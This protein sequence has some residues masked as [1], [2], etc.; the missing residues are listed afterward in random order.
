MTPMHAFLTEMIDRAGRSFATGELAYLALTSKIERPF[1]DRLAFA[2][3]VELAPSGVHVAREFF[4]AGAGRADVAIL[5]G[6]QTLCLVEGKAMA[7]ADCT[8]AEPR[9]REYA[10]LLQR[11]LTRYSYSA[12]PTAEIYSLLLGVH[13]LARLPTELRR[14]VKYVGL[15][16]SAFGLLHSADK[17]YAEA[18]RNLRGYLLN[19]VIVGAGAF[20]A[21]A[22]FGIPVEVRWWLFGPFHAPHELQILREHAV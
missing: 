9:R 14:V 4:V 7:V 22:A 11:D 15:L 17:I 10:D 20:D 12:F 5:R 6:E 16:N 13:P 8:R 19:D 3:Q 18:N 21:G 2:A 1:L